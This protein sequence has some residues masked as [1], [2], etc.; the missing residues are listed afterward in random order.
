MP[1]IGG[2]SSPGTGHFGGLIETGH[3]HPTGTVEATRVVASVCRRIDAEF[4]PL[5]VIGAPHLGDISERALFRVPLKPHL[6]NQTCELVDTP[7]RLFKRG[8]W[9][10]AADEWV[11]YL[12]DN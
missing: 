8:G 1:A 10:V 7:Q 9:L 2:V 12:E 4:G 11:P 6:T 5:N 3:S